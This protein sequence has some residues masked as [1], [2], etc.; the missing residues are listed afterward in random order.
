MNPVG[1]LGAVGYVVFWNITL[2][3][4]G[5]FGY[6]LYQLFRYLS[7]GRE[8]EKYRHLVKRTLTG[9]GH[10]IIQECQFKNLNRRDR[11]GLGHV[12][13]AWGFLF[14]ATY[15]FFFIIIGFGFGISESIEN[16]VI[17]VIYTWIMDLVAPLIMLGALW[18]ILRRYVVR[19]AR[20][21]GQKSF[22]ALLILV[23]VFIHPITHLG[24]IG[25]QIAAG[26]APA[27]LGMAPPPISAA[28]SYLYP[29]GVALSTWHSLWFWSHWGFVLF[30][31]IIIGYT[32]YRHVVAAILNDIFVRPLPKGMPC[33]INLK[34][35]ATF[36]VARIDGFTQK[37]LLDLYA[38]VEPGHCQEVC[39][40]YFT[41]KPLNPRSV[42]QD[43]RTNLLANGPLLVENEAPILPLIADSQPGSV[44]EEVIWECTTCG[45]CMEICP[46][47]IEHVGHIID[48]RRNL[49]QMQAKFPEELLNLFE[50]MEQ[51]SNPWG[52]A[53]AERIKW[54]SDIEV[55]PFEAEKTEYLFYV[56]CAGAFS[57]RNRHTTQALAKI[58]T[59]AD[60]TWGTLGRDELCCGD[61]L[62]RLGNEYVFDRMA[63]ENV[64]LFAEKGVKKIITQCPHCF[65]TLKN[66]Y[67]QYGAELEVYHHSQVIRN[68]ITEGKLKT[69]KTVDL[70]N[71][72]FHDSCYLGRHNQ[73]YEAPRDVVASATG[74]TP[75]EMERHHNHSFCC[76]AGGGRMWMEEHLGKHINVARV[77]EAMKK[78]PQTICVSCPYCMTML[79]DGL[80]DLNAEDKV[81]VLDIAEVLHQAL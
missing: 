46:V 74:K 50:N 21:R 44:S 1:D 49:V 11:A 71:L 81:Q 38:C 22:T 65:S 8:E 36:G 72:L 2:F 62:R 13:M 30:V 35:E 28:I 75:G 20:L 43:L 48:L 56:G 64:R 6:R 69:E 37:Q 10:F 67:R 3:A 59:A 70:G 24:K 18:G 79:E 34:D 15:Y 47:R 73:I 40:A 19:P 41:G 26:Y 53:P 23:T 9:I 57:S 78:D 52:M 4:M 33:R 77:E 54:A 58:M 66:D 45:A 29:A 63:T 17:Y 76:G 7:L 31:M 60:V 25:T 14:F 68:L 5:I 55:M 42:I 27:G 51:R 80:K 16:N 12:L 32:R 39:P 61:S